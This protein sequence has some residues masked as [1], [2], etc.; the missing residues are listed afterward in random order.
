MNSPYKHDFQMAATHVRNESAFDSELSILRDV[1]RLLPIGV[2][3]QD[4]SGEILLAN[5][6]ATAL[7]QPAKAAPAPIK[8]KGGPM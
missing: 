8:K 3:V 2:T 1:F 6:A 7:L 4:E 5:D